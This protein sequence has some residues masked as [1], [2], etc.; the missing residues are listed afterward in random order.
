MIVSTSLTL[1]EAGWAAQ[2]VPGDEA[3]L[4]F[5]TWAPFEFQTL[6]LGCQLQRYPIMLYGANKPHSIFIHAVH[7]VGRDSNEIIK[8]LLCLYTDQP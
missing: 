3:W 1:E 5:F 7:V 8:L 6:S 2:R 4:T